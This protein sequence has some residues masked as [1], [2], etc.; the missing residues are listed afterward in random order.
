M[1]GNAEAAHRLA[2]PLCRHRTAEQVAELRQAAA[3]HQGPALT[4]AEVLAEL[5]ARRSR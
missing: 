1:N 2:C 5:A 3:D 4:V